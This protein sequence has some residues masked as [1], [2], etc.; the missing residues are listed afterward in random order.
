YIQRRDESRLHYSFLFDASRILRYLL[1]DPLLFR[2][3]LLLLFSLF[4]DFQICPKVSFNPVGEG[5]LYAQWGLVSNKKIKKIKP[6][7]LQ[8]KIA[9]FAS[10]IA[11]W[12]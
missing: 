4:F 3:A 5:G 9:V 11:E 12:R 1:A 6:R 10:R 7:I 2:L 8:S